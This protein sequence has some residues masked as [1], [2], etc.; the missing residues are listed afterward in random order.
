MKETRK[1]T[2]SAIFL[3]LGLVLPFLTM[4]IQ[5][6]GNMLLPM[7]IPVLLCGYVVGVPY[8]LIIGFITP[9]L[10]SFLFGM[11]MMLNAICMAFELAT[12][13]AIAGIMHKKLS[14]KKWYIYISLIIAMIAG[15]I[16]WGGAMYIC[17]GIKGGAFTLAAFFAGA[18]T[19]AIPGIIVQLVLIPIIV[20]MLEKAKV[21]KSKN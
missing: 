12:Y 4:Q 3:A 1:I 14:S 6:I 11:P 18:I 2:L 13:G 19:N 21:L 10:R 20:I 8:S 9:V 5:S 15:R 17:M 7:H 16:V